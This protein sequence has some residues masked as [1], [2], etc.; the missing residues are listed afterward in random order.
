MLIVVIH[1]NFWILYSPYDYCLQTSGSGVTIDKAWNWTA[2]S[3]Y[4]EQK[5]F[6][7]QVVN[8]WTY[9]VGIL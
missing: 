6:G 9:E 2:N 4:K 3:T 8:V 7:G 5:I 1:N